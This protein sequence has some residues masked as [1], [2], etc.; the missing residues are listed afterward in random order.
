M[1]RR[2]FTTLPALTLPAVLFVG[3]TMAAP[4]PDETPTGSPPA[5]LC[6]AAAPSGPAS[7]AVTVEGAVGEESKLTFEVP[8][9]IDRMQTT[10]IHEGSGDPVESGQLITVAFTSYRADNGEK[11]GSIGYGENAQRPTQISSE[12]IVGRIFGCASPG[13]RVVAA[14][15][16]LG[17]Y[18]EVVVYDFLEIVPSAAGEP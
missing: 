6:D 9:E 14:F 2:S 11:I 17:G 15:P 3:C 10:V 1:R 12:N 5:A 16:S 4:E 7:E 8:L 18:P 13:T